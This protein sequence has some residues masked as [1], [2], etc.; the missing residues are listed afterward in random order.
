MRSPD[1][2]GIAHRSDLLGES[3]KLSF[4]YSLIAARAL[5][6]ISR[7]RVATDAFMRAIIYRAAFFFVAPGDA[8]F[9]HFYWRIIYWGL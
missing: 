8:F 3:I 1:E 7:R 5:M 4:L 9:L 2:M 6:E